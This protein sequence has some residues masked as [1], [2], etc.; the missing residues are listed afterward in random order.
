MPD[1]ILT[2]E[3][4]NKLAKIKSDFEEWK[5]KAVTKEDLNNHLIELEKIQGR[6]NEIMVAA[7][8]KYKA[9][10]KENAPKAESDAT[11]KEALKNN[12]DAFREL[13]TT[14]NE[15]RAGQKS[16]KTLEDVLPNVPT[17]NPAFEKQFP[18]VPKGKLVAQ[19][20]KPQSRAAQQPAVLVRKKLS[21]AQT[22]KN[23]SIN[24]RY[25]SL[26]NMIADIAEASQNPNV[27]S[28]TLE[29]KKLFLR[30]QAQGLIREIN[31]FKSQVSDAAIK[32]RLDVFKGIIS[33]LT[34][35]V[36]APAAIKK[37]ES[38]FKAKIK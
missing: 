28:R 38:T 32:Q 31:L 7:D 8:T 9:L 17:S 11:A 30:Q 36:L 37:E 29:T 22:I 3:Q 14:R 33:Q 4:E 34:K 26:N 25:Q 16:V 13:Q 5:N 35:S 21:P 18:E 10:Y 15:I 1:S 23:E 2:A 12:F 6:M 24:K 20:Q 19:N 27:N